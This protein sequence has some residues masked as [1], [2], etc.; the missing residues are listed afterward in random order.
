M[1]HPA[2]FLLA[3]TC[4]ATCATVQAADSLGFYIGGAVGQ[5]DVRVDSS[6]ASTSSDVSEH[7]AGWKAIVGVRPL[8][9]VGA[10]LE[11]LDFGN[12]SYAFATPPPTT[13]G[14][15]DSKAAA[16]FGVLYVP[17]PVPFFDV[18]GKVGVARLRTDV[19]GMITG[20]FCP[21]SLPNCGTI[22]I[23][24]T[25]TDL[26]YGAGVQFKFAS[27]AV[28][29]EYERID[30]SNGSPDMLSLGFTWTF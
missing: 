3:F 17:I 2:F 22:A 5:A 10:E 14:A 23:S 4:A 8:S 24:R 18:Y 25:D 19:N 9:F 7:H 13:M 30:S 29:A 27:A 21:V 15:V 16:L 28:R 12:P 26:G 6:L 20:L 11:Y 1:K